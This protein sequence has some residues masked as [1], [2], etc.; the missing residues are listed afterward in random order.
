MAIEIE[1]TGR[2][3]P[4]LVTVNADVGGKPFPEVKRLWEKTSEI[5]SP[6]VGTVTELSFGTKDAV[7]VTATS[8]N[9]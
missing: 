1:V 4:S 9:D 5:L 3:T 6:V 8:V 7:F 2:A